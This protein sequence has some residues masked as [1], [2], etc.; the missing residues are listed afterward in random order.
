MLVAGKTGTAQTSRGKNHG[1]FAGFAPFD[2]AQLVVVV[3]D[4]YG[5]RGGYYAAALA[6]QVFQKAADLGIIK[7]GNVQTKI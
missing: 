4:E 5:G 6:G 7:V 3:F 1:W 2:N